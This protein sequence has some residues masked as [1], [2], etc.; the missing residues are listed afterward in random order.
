MDYKNQPGFSPKNEGRGGRDSADDRPKLAKEQ[1][2]VTAGQ[3]P[4]KRAHESQPAEY[5]NTE[6]CRDKMPLFDQEGNN[7]HEDVK[8]SNFM[9]EPVDTDPMQA[10]GRASAG[11]DQIFDYTPAEKRTASVGA[12][13][14]T[15]GGPGP[16]LPMR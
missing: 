8:Y 7:D 1:M 14:V 15:Q 5:A 12:E 2:R 4:P 3:F 11:Q 16:E 13:P 6:E 9:M 10:P